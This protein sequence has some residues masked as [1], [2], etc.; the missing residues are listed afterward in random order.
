MVAQQCRFLFA[1]V[2]KGKGKAKKD[3]CQ[4]MITILSITAWLPA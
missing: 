4:I 1:Q 2:G 3:S